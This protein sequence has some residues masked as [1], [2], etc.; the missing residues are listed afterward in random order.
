MSFE[1]LQEG[2]NIKKGCKPLFADIII[3]LQRYVLMPVSRI[4]TCFFFFFY[5]ID[6]I[7]NPT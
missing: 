6:F 3:L 1:N 4:L 2:L 7:V 5:Y